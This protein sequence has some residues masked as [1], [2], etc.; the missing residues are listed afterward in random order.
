[1]GCRHLSRLLLLLVLLTCQVR[2]AK[3][4]NVDEDGDEDG[5]GG[6]TAYDQLG[7]WIDD[8]I[9][10]KGGLA[11]VD[12]IAIY[13][14]AKELGIESKHKTLTVLAQTIFDANI[15]KKKQIEAHKG[16]LKKVCAAVFSL[17]DPL[18]I[19]TADDYFREARESI[20]RRH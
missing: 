1:M 9:K 15:T 7:S 10:E 18:L 14:K 4:L 19:T 13:Q 2:L 11:K 6:P 17:S 3:T 20:P 8:Q 5:D 16:M 12:D